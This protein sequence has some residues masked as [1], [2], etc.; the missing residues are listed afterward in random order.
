MAFDQGSIPATVHSVIQH[1]NAVYATQF[2]LGDPYWQVDAEIVDDNIIATITFSEDFLESVEGLLASRELQ[3]FEAFDLSPTEIQLV[4]Q[5]DVPMSPYGKYISEIFLKR[6][7]N[8]VDAQFTAST[9]DNF[10]VSYDE[11]VIKFKAASYDK[12]RDP[13][14]IWIS[15]KEFIDSL[16]VT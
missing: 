8:A 15:R 14:T 9:G 1:V 10:R 3:G 6:V 13:L 5:K 16:A 7:S 12:D 11:A 4:I 2:S